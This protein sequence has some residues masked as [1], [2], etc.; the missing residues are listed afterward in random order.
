MNAFVKESVNVNDYAQRIA[1][2]LPRGILLNTQGEKFNAMVIGWGHLGV[3]WSVPTFVVYV[4]RSRY[5]KA[6]LDST[7]CFTVSVPL[8]GV[9]PVIQRVCGSQSGRDIDKAK[10]AGLTLVP[11]E[12]VA[13]SAVLEYPLTLECRVLYSQ[14]QDLARLP[15]DIRARMYPQDVDGSFPLANRDP[16]TAYVGQIVSSYI[17]REKA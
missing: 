9:N 3:L 11:A 10:E 12:A 2:A 17:I 14:E 4:R 1:E 15:E 6:Q 13:G 5:T 16:H 8:G 7:G